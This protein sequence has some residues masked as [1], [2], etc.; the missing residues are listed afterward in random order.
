[1]L[2]LRGRKFLTAFKL[3]FV[4]YIFIY[5]IKKLF[6]ANTK[7]QRI[8]VA[9]SFKTTRKLIDHA[10]SLLTAQKR[11]HFFLQDNQINPL[12]NFLREASDEKKISLSCCEYESFSQSSE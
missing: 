1:M 5:E 6:S 10:F 8:L 2:V 12:S 4:V 11:F 9:E 7:I 3:F